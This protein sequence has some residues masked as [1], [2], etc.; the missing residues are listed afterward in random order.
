MNKNFGL[1]GTSYESEIA[2]RDDFKKQILKEEE[3]CKGKIKLLKQKYQ[4][5]TENYE[6]MKERLKPYSHRADTKD[7]RRGYKRVLVVAVV[8][9][10]I[11]LSIISL[12]SVS[13]IRDY[14][15]GLLSSF[16]GS[17][18]VIRTYN[19]NVIVVDKSVFVPKELP[20]GYDFYR[21]TKN[22]ETMHAF[23]YM[24][25]DGHILTFTQRSLDEDVGVIDTEGTVSEV[26]INGYRGSLLIK[27]DGSCS[28]VWSTPDNIFSLTADTDLDLISI[29]ESV[30][31]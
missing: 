23:E 4:L 13:S 5:S 22:G 16:D 25:Q 11:I 31:Q 26:T 10:L 18:G 21:M 19:D 2:F 3:G 24:D 7:G 29:G 30:F 14:A 9:V 6:K 12:V 17:Y 8:V 20:E 1:D 27:D 15:L 28:L